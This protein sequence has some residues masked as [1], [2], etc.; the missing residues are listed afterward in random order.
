MG[1][2]GHK[3]G[4]PPSSSG[5]LLGR[6]RNRPDSEHE[7]ALI[8]VGFACLTIAYCF[9]LHWTYDAGAEWSQTFAYPLVVASVG[10]VLSLTIV[11]HILWQP[12]ISVIRRSTAMVIDIIFLS[13]F[14]HFG[15]AYT[16]L[17]YPIYLWVTFGMG[18]RYGLPYL[19]AATALSLI[20]FVIVIRTTPYWSDQ[21]YL[22]VGLLLALFVLPAYASS[23]LVKLTKAKAQAEEANQAKS[24][25]LANMSHEL[26]TP[27][28]AVIGMSDLLDSARLDR[29]QADMV[30]SIRA[31]GRALLSLINQVLDFSRIESAKVTVQSEDFD[32]HTLLASLG[33]MMRPQSHA[34]DLTF[35]VHLAPQVP[36]QL[37]GDKQHLNQVL[38][39][40]IFN[41]LKFTETGGVSLN[42]ST[43]PSTEESWRLRFEVRDTGIGIKPEALS[44]IFESFTQADDAINRRYGG[45]GLGLTI[46]R[47]LIEAMG[48]RIGVDSTYGEGSCFWFELPFENAQREAPKTIPDEAAVVCLSPKHRDDLQIAFGRLG[49]PILEI[50]ESW[51]PAAQCMTEIAGQTSARIALCLDLR[52]LGDDLQAHIDEIQETGLERPT[53][54]IAHEE[55]KELEG[56]L[57]SNVV[58]RLNNL[59]DTGA[60]ANALR[61][62][63]L[64]ETGGEPAKLA[65]LPRSDRGLRI[66]VADDNNVNRRVVAKILEHMGFEAALVENGEQALDLLDA[67]DFDLVLMDMQMPVMSGVEAT[68]FYR[69][70]NIGGP[71]LP[72]VALTA[73]ATTTAK[74]QALEAGMDACLTKPVEPAH[75]LETIE[76]LVPSESGATRG[77]DTKLEPDL[78]VVTHPRFS[79]ERHPVLDYRTLEKLMML[80]SSASFLTSLIDDFLSDGEQLLGELKTAAERKDAREFRDIIHGLRG[81]AMNIGGLSLY[82]LLLTYRGIN[83]DDLDREGADYLARIT[84][85]FYSLR[86][87]LSQYVREHEGEELPS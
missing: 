84:E 2:A 23:L 17:W 55:Q 28:N 39:N 7:Q 64:Y 20:S 57:D 71:H 33:A 73:D 65:A 12:G 80:D 29:E 30:R 16:A 19:I 75:L 49:V 5:G 68:K 18:F 8:R 62:A 52:D 13:V 87:A 53:V 36:V 27:L 9:G 35:E 14:M 67:Q 51:A 77:S 82:N 37:H 34:K 15:G 32:L 41:A 83:Q 78:K 56:L 24:R 50:F 38:V 81:S 63:L 79:A 10:L 25:F 6:L 69:M 31:S 48:G 43:C 54:L 70:A 60:L 74:E 11:A 72:I 45:T 26:R 85:E 21:T 4:R 22:S 46:C 86:A 42:V 47:Q 61:F 58:V 66:L 40:L 1:N 59:T 3:A 76:S 44:R